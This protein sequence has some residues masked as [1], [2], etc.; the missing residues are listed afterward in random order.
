MQTAIFI[1]HSEGLRPSDSP[2]RSLAGPRTPHSARVGSLARSFASVAAQL[3]V[4]GEFPVVTGNWE[5]ELLIK[6]LEQQRAV[7]PPEP[8]R[9]G[10][11][12][13]NRGRAVDVRDVV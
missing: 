12:I 5:L 10:Q 6:L 9:I 7:R 2:T 4:T 11:R 8:E 3:P 13:L 1:N